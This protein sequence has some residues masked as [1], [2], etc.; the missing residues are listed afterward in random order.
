MAAG[1]KKKTEGATTPRYRIG[2][3][4]GGTKMMA[5]VFDAAYKP[6]A[7]IRKKTTAD[8]TGA[9]L[10]ADIRETIL[11]AMEKAGAGH[12][13]VV[14]VGIGTPGPVDA[15]SGVVVFAPN[16]G[17]DHFPLR[18]K[19][20]KALKLPV[21]VENDVNCGIVA[22]L[23]FGAA[24]GCRTV[25]GVFPG[26][27]I[28]GG[29]VIDGRLFRGASGAAGE[30]GHTVVDPLGPRCGCGKRGC[31]EAIAARPAIAARAAMLAMRGEAPWLAENIGTD[32]ADIRSGA[33]ARSVKAGDKAI[34]ELLADSA[35][36]IGWSLSGV[37]NAL[38][39]DTVIL[40]GGLVEALPELFVREVT[41]GI[42]DTVVSV[43][44]D[45]LTVKAALL[46][47]YAVA[48]G[49]AKLLDDSLAS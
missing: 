10:L 29:V 19:L 36:R 26:T 9:G 35:R 24:E 2:F 49:A 22:E 42:R 3:D 5:V 37:L 11:A 34:K 48:L 6:V 40:G 44:A 33:L 7:R 46:G 23:H 43:I 25:L 8:P 31:I 14:G 41:K 13:D 27:G 28:G 12:D 18:A 21:T 38:S 16:L 1:T 45:S 39:P 4:L 30:I 20:A 47:D 17:L 32:P 15:T